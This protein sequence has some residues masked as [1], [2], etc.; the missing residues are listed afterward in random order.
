MKTTAQIAAELQGY[1]PDALRAADV[2]AFLERLVEPVTE[3]QEIGLF[4]ALGRVLARDVVSPI[5]VP[6]HDNSAMDGYAFDGRAL[7]TAPRQHGAW[8]WQ[9]VGTALAGQP[10]TTPLAAGQTLRIMTGAVMPPGAD[11]VIP[12]ERCT[13]QGDTLRLE[14]GGGLKPG[15]NRRRPSFRRPRPP[16]PWSPHEHRSRTARHIPRFRI[17]TLGRPDT[18]GPGAGAAGGGRRA[19]LRANRR[20][21][22]RRVAKSLIC[23]AKSAAAGSGRR[24]R[25]VNSAT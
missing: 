24:R 3:T 11:T 6:P 18:R 13:R 1:D 4:D 19:A 21:W 12:H 23:S 14:H 25:V 7:L 9:V 22:P 16:P 8:E 20:K 10:W 17:A 15:A 5:S 2:G